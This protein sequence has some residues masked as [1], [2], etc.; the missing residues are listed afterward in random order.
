MGQLFC[1]VV[2]QPLCV[3]VAH[4][5]LYQNTRTIK[6]KDDTLEQEQ[7]IHK[8]SNNIIKKLINDVVN[9]E[10]P[11]T[12][13]LDK[14]EIKLLVDKL[15]PVRHLF[16]HL[17]KINYEIRQNMKNLANQIHSHNGEYYEGSTHPCDG[18]SAHDTTK[19]YFNHYFRNPERYARNSNIGQIANNIK[20]K[21]DEYHIIYDFCKQ[22]CTKKLI[23]YISNY[24]FKY[25]I[26]RK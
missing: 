18:F 5:Q 4:N 19:E 21:L 7:F 16:Y 17:S 12:P 22:L 2:E 23:R 6:A 9:L 15:L 11:D 8:F 26:I 13:I 3:I 1:S 20:T 14:F 24:S 25:A 10:I